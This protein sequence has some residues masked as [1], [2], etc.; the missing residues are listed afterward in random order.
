MDTARVAV[1]AAPSSRSSPGIGPRTSSS[2][3]PHL[4]CQDRYFAPTAAAPTATQVA[5]RNRRMSFMLGECVA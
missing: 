1:K 4:R 2:V 3:A 5:R